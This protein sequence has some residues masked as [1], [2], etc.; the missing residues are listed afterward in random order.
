MAWL[1]FVF[2]WGVWGDLRARPYCFPLLSDSEGAS[3]FLSALRIVLGVETG[4]L[5]RGRDERLLRGRLAARTAC[6]PSGNSPVLVRVS[7]IC[8][9][10]GAGVVL[11]FSFQTE[12]PSL[13][14]LLRGHVVDAAAL[15]WEATLSLNKPYGGPLHLTLDK[16][17]RMITEHPHFSTVKWF[18]RLRFPIWETYRLAEMKVPCSLIKYLNGSECV[19]IAELYSWSGLVAS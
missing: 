16:C 10:S 17:D 3:L 12:S 6:I 11:R 4:W 5:N 8:G 2:G 14:N 1:C 19:L 13:N 7:S 9:N 18:W 15:E